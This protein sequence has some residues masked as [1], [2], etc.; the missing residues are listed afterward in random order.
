LVQGDTAHD[1]LN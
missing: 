1:L